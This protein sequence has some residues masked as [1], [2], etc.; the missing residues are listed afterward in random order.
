MSDRMRKIMRQGGGR[1]NGKI[2]I[3]TGAG[4]RNPVVG[5]GRA[6]SILFAREGAKVLLVD[7]VPENAEKTLSAIQEEGGEASV[8]TADVSNSAECQAMA[9][10]AVERYGELHILFNNVGIAARVLRQRHGCVVV[11]TPFPSAK[12][13]TIVLNIVIRPACNARIGTV[14]AK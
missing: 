8:F 12:T 3:V 2:A 14:A 6:A 10:V 11:I 1:L 5:V 9:E 4:T 13:I 7:M